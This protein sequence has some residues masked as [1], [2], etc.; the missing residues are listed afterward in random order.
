MGH[1]P[2]GLRIYLNDGVTQGFVPASE[3][4]VSVFDHG[5]LYGDGVFEGIRVYNWKVFRL[6]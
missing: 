1:V 2:D 4:K 5:Y 6:T 3:A